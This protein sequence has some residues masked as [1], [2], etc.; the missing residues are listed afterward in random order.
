MTLF[1][2]IIK[3]SIFWLPKD[4]WMEIK[5]QY[6]LM[7]EKDNEE[8]E[9]QHSEFYYHRRSGYFQSNY[10]KYLMKKEYCYLPL[11]NAHCYFL[12]FIA[13]F[14]DVY[15]LFDKRYSRNSY[16]SPVVITMLC[17][18]KSKQ[19]GKNDSFT[20]NIMNII[21]DKRFNINHIIRW[22]KQN[23]Q[24]QYNPPKSKYEIYVYVNFKTIKIHK[25][26]ESLNDYYQEL[27]LI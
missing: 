17:D 27:K 2:I 20:K 9:T 14:F 7:K 6:D 16:F 11:K 22:L 26:P 25:S 24:N 10:T 8:Y 13:K 5:K 1:D 23:I 3:Y 21:T 12:V 18:V 15:C 4:M 19:K